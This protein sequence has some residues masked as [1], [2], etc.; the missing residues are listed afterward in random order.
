MVSSK[1]L[2]GS[3]RDMIKPVYAIGIAAKKIGVSVHTLRLYESEGLL[4]PY[5]TPTLRR[6]YSDLEIDKALGIRKMI[7]THGLNFEAIRKM[8]AFV[9]CWKIRKCTKKQ[10]ESCSAYAS[11]DKPCWAT[12]KKCDAPLSSCR[13][14][15]V[16]QKISSYEDIKTFLLT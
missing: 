12:K 5:K 11:E 3:N 10:R 13:M 15:P 16:Y 4:I 8:F 7:R 2:K 6:I 9:P 1:T 14:C